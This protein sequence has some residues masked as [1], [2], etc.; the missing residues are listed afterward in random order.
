MAF[1]HGKDTVVKINGSDISAFTNN[2]TLGDED[3]L[4]DTTCYG[5]ERKTYQAGLGDGTFT[6]SGIYDDS[7]AGPRAI[8]KP[9]KAA[10]LPVTFIYQPEGTGVGKAQTSVS[11]FV[12]TF[13]ESSPVADNVTWTSELQMTG[14]LNETDQV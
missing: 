3:D 1:K 11:V 14:D 13:N 2:C 10:K 6:I 5:Q 8:I 4:H 7:A 9:L 12:K